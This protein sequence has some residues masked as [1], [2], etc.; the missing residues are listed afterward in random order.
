M[1]D[2]EKEFNS[3]EY[4]IWAFAFTLLAELL[5]GG[6]GRLKTRMAQVLVNELQRTLG[7]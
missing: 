7:G 3:L 5:P 6:R 2:T 4:N 1:G